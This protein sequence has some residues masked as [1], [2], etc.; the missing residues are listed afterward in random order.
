MHSTTLFQATQAVS[1]H[2]ERKPLAVFHDDSR[3]AKRVFSLLLMLRIVPLC[4]EIF[5]VS[6][7]Y[8]TCKRDTVWIVL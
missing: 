1:Y 5:L 6:F 3:C 4:K 7:R 2:G 8:P